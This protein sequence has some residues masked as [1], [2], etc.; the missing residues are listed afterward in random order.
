MSPDFITLAHE[1]EH[2]GDFEN[3][4]LA[5][6]RA[7]I[8]F[9]AGLVLIAG[10]E[11]YVTGWGLGSLALERLRQ[12]NAHYARE[13]LPVRNAALAAAGAA[14]DTQV[15]GERRVKG[16]RYFR[17][18]ASTVSVRHGLLGY[19]RKAGR[20]FGVVVLGRSGSDFA[21]TE[22]AALE[23][24]LPV[25]SLARASYA[26]P[27]RAAALPVAP[28]SRW[29]PFGDDNRVLARRPLGQ[30]EVLVRDRGS[31]REMVACGPRSELVW[32]RS[33]RE[34]PGRSGWPYADLFHLA[35]A[36]AS[37]RRRALFIGSGGA[38]SVQ[39]F[40]EVYPGIAIDLVEREASVLDL[41]ETW[42]GL[43][44]V[45]GVTVHVADGVPFVRDAPDNHWD[46]VVVDAFDARALDDGV[47][48]ETFVAGVHRVLQPGGAVACN[49]IDT[50]SGPGPLAR[51][52]SAAR[53][54]F[55]DVSIVPVLGL[56]E[57]FSP[58]SQRNV[59]LVAVRG[60]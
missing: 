28:R 59:V 51:F 12:R 31:Q 13:L 32:T 36:R 23:Q 18:I 27:F 56:D 20:P 55:E 57:D 5:S 1:H 22:V 15:L 38:V 14:V 2:V 35:A 4:V 52:V 29:S 21:H 42:F 48:S 58:Y 7:H 46:V 9:D 24:H 53:G 50:L 60:R 47:T 40:A 39:R 54:R 34:H 37:A 44:S 8:G 25:L 49:V 3:A 19:L 11:Q 43:G 45:P 30:G 16:S 26:A 6:L 17:D 33:E 10:Q 41:A